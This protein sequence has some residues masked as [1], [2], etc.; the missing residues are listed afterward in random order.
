MKKRFRLHH[1][2]TL[3]SNLHRVLQRCRQFLATLL[4]LPVFFCANAQELIAIPALHAH[5]VDQID[6]LSA[7]EQAQLDRTL[8]DYEQRTGSQIA[9]LLIAS[10]APETIEQFSIRVA[11]AWKIGRKN[12]DDGVILLVAKDNPKSLHRLRIEAG[13]G[14]QG[15][16]TDLQSKRILQEVIA[17]FFQ[18]NDFNGG[19]TAGVTAL[20]TLL[21]KEQLPAPAPTAQPASSVSDSFASALPFLLFVAFIALSIWLR[22]RQGNSALSHGGWGRSAGVILGSGI[23]FG[24]DHSGSSSGSTSG[25]MSGGG[26]SFDGG[27][28]S[29]DW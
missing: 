22:R 9:V 16:L 27:G 28:A 11:D 5:V 24:N 12:V 7:A 23:G 18:R 15:S 1:R 26:G 25:G 19:L 17:P 3:A 14:V 20:M 10:T 21:D 4:L 29:G 2:L 8:T 6:L 13:R